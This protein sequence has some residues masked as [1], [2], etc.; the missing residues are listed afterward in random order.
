VHAPA[1]TVDIGVADLPRTTSVSRLAR[2][3]RQMVRTAEACG[4]E[5]RGAFD[6]LRPHLQ[7]LW[8]R[9]PVEERH[10]FLRHLRPWWEIHR[11]RMAPS[12]AAELE[13]AMRRGQL[14]V[15][16]ARIVA[17]EA[18]ETSVLARVRRR[19]S[20]SIENLEVARAINCSG[21]ETNYKASSDPLI[22]DLLARGFARPDPLGLGLE[23]SEQ[24]AL[25][26]S[27]GVASRRLFALGP[28]TRGTFWEIV[29]VPD[30]RLHCARLA[31]HLSAGMR[32]GMQASEPGR[33]PPHPVPTGA[34]ERSRRLKSPFMGLA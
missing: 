4:Y 2:W 13:A 30:I 23:V 1:R 8:R 15:G 10:R 6:G 25:I 5:W 17:I 34:A 26:N 18:A 28:V 33:K 24:G 32:E 3:L 31:N 7:D 22:R 29:A 16:A 20:S 9:L 11:H 12:V 21:P 27:N 19:G 14:L